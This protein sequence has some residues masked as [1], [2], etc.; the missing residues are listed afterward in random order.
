MKKQKEASGDL[1]PTI[2]DLR[3][4]LPNSWRRISS[5]VGHWKTSA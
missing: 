4:P 5:D 2:P 3:P 1:L